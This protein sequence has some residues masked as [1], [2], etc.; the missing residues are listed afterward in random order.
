[1]YRL[2]LL[3]TARIQ[4]NV[5]AVYGNRSV[6][7][8]QRGQYNLDSAAHKRR[9]LLLRTHRTSD[10]R[11]LRSTSDWRAVL[12][13]LA[14]TILLAAL[15]LACGDD[16]SA[17]APS[18]TPESSPGVTASPDPG[19]PAPADPALAQQ[20]FEDFVSA[21]QDGQLEEAWG[22]YIASVPGDTEQH[23]ATLGCD[24]FAF[25]NE[26]DKMKHMFHRLE[27]L[28]VDEVFRAATASLS[29][30]LKLSGADDN[31]YLATLQREP[32]DA[33]YRVRSFNNG[34]PALQP[35]VPDPFPSPEDPQGFCA[36]WTGP[37]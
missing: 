29:V 10:M 25:A 30:E 36:I 1:L 33:V 4:A 9:A 13:L 32:A 19:T 31:S 26:F 15:P 21:V 20:V 18:Q 22:L 16:D 28:A 17:S 3:R 5:L 35:G 27:P 12:F 7:A 8:G 24:F 11:R 2:G 37:R 23:N 6:A 14:A 34:R